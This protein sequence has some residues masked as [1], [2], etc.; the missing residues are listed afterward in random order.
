MGWLLHVLGVDNMNG[1]AY[2][3][4]SGFG[5]D[6]GQVTL[7]G[8]VIGMFA[9]HNCHQKGCPRI[10]RHVVDGTPYCNKHHQAARTGG[11]GERGG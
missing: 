7:I 4:W 10:G 8:A 1:H 2:A 6:I 3:F 5:S 11:G 9:K